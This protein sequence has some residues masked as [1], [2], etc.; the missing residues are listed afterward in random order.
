MIDT[1]G[2][3]AFSGMRA[4]GASATDIIICVIAAESGIQPQT[5]EV[6][7]LARSSNCTVIA[8]VTKMDTLH[9][10]SERQHALKTI[11][12]QLMEHGWATEAYGGDTP[13]GKFPYL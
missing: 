8:A 11:N 9:E 7:K 2:H 4:S 13:L 12:N 1:P 5:I 3:A 10:P 6:L